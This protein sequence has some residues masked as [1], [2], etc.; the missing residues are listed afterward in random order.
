MKMTSSNTTISLFLFNFKVPTRDGNVS[1]HMV[2][3]RWG[4]SASECER[5]YAK[6]TLVLMIRS[7]RGERIMAT[8]EVENSISMIE[9]SPDA[10]FS[11]EGVWK[12]SAKGSVEYIR[13]PS[14]VAENVSIGHAQY[15]E[16]RTDCEEALILVEGDV[17]D[18]RHGCDESASSV[19]MVVEQ[20]DAIANNAIGNV[21]LSEAHVHC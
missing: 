18:A 13:N 1:S 11:V 17:V 10:P 5:A 7:S 2:D 21:S 14:V 9:T 20:E 19:A 6:R 4:I 3:C 15:S 12:T 16:T 8:S